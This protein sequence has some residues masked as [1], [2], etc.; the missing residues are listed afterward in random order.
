MRRDQR[1]VMASLD[2]LEAT[3]AMDLWRPVLV[4]S[5]GR[6]E[7]APRELVEIVVQHD[8]VVWQVFPQQDDRY[9][10]LDDRDGAD[11]LLVQSEWPRVAGDGWVVFAERLQRRSAQLQHLQ[12]TLDEFRSGWGQVQRPLRVGDAF[13]VRPGYW[14]DVSE[15]A[16]EQAKIA[17]DI[18]AGPSR[19]YDA[20][21]PRR[22]APLPVEPQSLVQ[23]VARPAI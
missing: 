23:N 20:P 22:N 16:R 9:V 21:R 4:A 1:P 19:T 3:E 11:L 18:A 15:A 2:E 8:D 7:L 10:V 5:K 14:L 13:L 6:D 17:K 12:R